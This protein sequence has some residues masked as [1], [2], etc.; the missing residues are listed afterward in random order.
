[1]TGPRRGELRPTLASPGRNAAGGPA[2][3]LRAKAKVELS[4]VLNLSTLGLSITVSAGLKEP[5][6]GGGGGGGGISLL[7]R[8][9]LGTWLSPR[10]QRGTH[11]SCR[12]WIGAL[13]HFRSH[14]WCAPLS[15]PGEGQGLL[16]A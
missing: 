16:P 8:V 6:R 1:M 10:R 5:D 9:T 13:Y 14:N 2:T 4:E 15:G 7:S 11:A 12:G 3:D